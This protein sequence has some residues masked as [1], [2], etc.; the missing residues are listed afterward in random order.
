MR[1]RLLL[2]L[3]G[4]LLAFG[5]GEGALALFAPQIMRSPR[6]WDFDPELGWANRPGARGRL[7]APE[8]DVEMAIDAEGL[9]GPEVARAKLSGTRRI[10]LFGDSFAMG[11]GVAEDDTLRA[12]LALQL[13]ARDP[14]APVEVLN[15]GVAGYS[16]DQELLA[17]RKLGARFAPDVVVLVVYGNDFW[18]NG[19]EM[20]N[21]GGGRL[22]AR[23]HFQFAPAGALRLVGTPIP[24]NTGWDPPSFP[25]SHWFAHIAADGVHRSHVASLLLRA[26]AP[27]SRLP[28]TSFY[29]QRIYARSPD[30]DSRTIWELTAALIARFDQEVRAAGARFVLVYASDRLEVDPDAWN[31]ARTA[32]GFG[33]DLDPNRP[34]RE[35]ARIA[36]A[37][38]IAFVDLLPEMRSAP[39]RGPFFFREGHWNAAGHAIAAETVAALLSAQ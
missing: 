19:N 26:V 39:A 4:A 18:E 36:R 17:F 33:D 11:W 28:L 30:A 31:S 3:F 7:V 8:F 27:T 32:T 10:A 23:P 22:V 25:S 15:F 14:N 12:Q 20:G 16:T 29:Y 1:S 6:V 38:D 9:R 34:S 13:R 24:R 35:L 2:L 21:G 5:L 37:H